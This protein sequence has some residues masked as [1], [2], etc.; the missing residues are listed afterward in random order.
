MATLTD[1]QRAAGWAAFMASWPLGELAA[2]TKTDGR[3]AYDAADAWVSANSTAYNTALPLPFRTA[4]SSKLKAL[5]LAKV[6]SD[7][8]NLNL[9]A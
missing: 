5:L 8:W 9:F 1:P 7:R 2:F 4:A 6:I 3:A